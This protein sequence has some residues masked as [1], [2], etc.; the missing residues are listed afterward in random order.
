[1]NCHSFWR[2][3]FLGFHTLT[4]LGVFILLTPKT[5]S[6]S[7][8]MIT[9]VELKTQLANKTLYLDNVNWLLS[10]NPEITIVD[11]YVTEGINIVFY[12]VNDN[13]RI[14]LADPKFSL[15]EDDNKIENV[16][17]KMK[18]FCKSMTENVKGRMIVTKTSVIDSKISE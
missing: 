18:A 2:Y 13:K 16:F 15:K 14:R 5:S 9:E 4:L 12:E 17:V 8:K 11:N 1:M 6:L 3:V 7:S 10:K